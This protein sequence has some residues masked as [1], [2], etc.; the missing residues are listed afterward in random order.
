VKIK[1]YFV[2]SLIDNFE[3]VSGYSKKFGII[4]VN[5]ET[6]DRT[7]KKSAYWYKNVIKENGFSYQ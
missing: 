6:L 5:P 1:S 7:R 3:W 4:K 2:W